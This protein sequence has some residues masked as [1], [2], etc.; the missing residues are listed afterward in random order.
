MSGFRITGSKLFLLSLLACLTAVALRAQTHGHPTTTAMPRITAKVDDANRVML[1]GNIHPLATA[2]HDLGAAP[3]SLEL[4]RAILVLKST[5]AQQAALTKLTDDQHNPKS[6]NYHVWLTPAEY[7][8]R[9]G[10]ASQDLAKIDGWLEGHGFTIEPQMAG[11]NLIIFSGTNAKLMQAFHT[12]L[13]TY[14]VKG[15]TYTA[16]SDNPQIPAAFSDLI[17]SFSPNNFPVQAQHTIPRLMKHTDAGWKDVAGVKPQT[18]LPQNGTT[19]YA[20]TPYDLATIYNILPLWNAGIDGTGETIAIVADSN[21]NPA[22]VDTFRS[23]FGLPAKKLNIINYGPDPGRNDDESEADLDVQWSGAV[24]KNATIDLVVANNSY[25]S[26]GI[27]GSAA[28]VVNNNLAPLLNV[29]FGACEQAFGTAENQ[30]INLLWQ[31]AASQ[32]I[33]VLVATGDSDAAGCD[34]GSSIASS[35]DA[36][37]GIASTPYDISVGGTDFSGNFPDP[38]RYWSAENNATTA[39]SVLSYIPE[40]AWNNSCANPVIL[41]AELANG[42]TSDATTQALCNDSSLAQQYLNTDGGGGAASNCAVAGPDATN[43]CGS[44]Y[45]KPAWQSGVLGIPADGVRDTPDVSL[46]AGNGVWG[47]FYL[48]CDSDASGGS[49]DTTSYVSAGGTSFA[50][51]IFAGMLALVQ[52]KEQAA[53]LGNVN[54]VLYKLGAAEYNNPSSTTCSSSSVTPGNSCIFYDITQGSNSAPCLIYTP[55]CG[56]GTA[57]ERIGTL[58]GY[59]ANPGY[60]VA[61]GLGTINAY[62][63]V[64]NW[65]SASSTFLP[66]T[67]RV[68]LTDPTSVVY[69]QNV[70]LSVVVSPIAPATG[71]PSGDVG[72]TSNDPAP[73]SISLNETTLSQGH[74]TV[75][76]TPLSAGSYQ[77]FANYAGDATFAPSA[78]SG[79]T[80]NVVKASAGIVLTSTSSVVQSS[81]NVT[82]SL[83][84]NSVLNGVAPTGTVIFTN[85]ATGAVLTNEGLAESSTF[86]GITTATWFATVP[87]SQLQSGANTITASYS[88]DSNYLG[89]LAAP[90][91]VSSAQ[92]AFVTTISQP[93]VTLTNGSGSLSVLITPSGSTPLTPNSIVLSC[94]T[95]VGLIC[96]FSPNVVSN[97]GALTST[98]SVRLAPSSLSLAASRADSNNAKLATISLAGGMAGLMLLMVPKRRKNYGLLSLCIFLLSGLML[99]VGCSSG[100]HNSSSSQS[101]LVATSTLLSVNSSTQLAGAA[102]VFTAK[103]KPESGTGLPTGTI[104]FSAGSAKLGTSPLIGESATFTTTSLPLGS[105]AVIATYSGDSTY[106]ISSSAVMLLNV[107]STVALKVAA[108]DAFSNQSSVNV[109]VIIQ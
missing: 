71:V 59:Y 97:S 104:M 84:A 6:P 88:G 87:Q 11:R 38:T 70:S 74:G 62:N 43:P 27:F 75:A 14:K 68:S 31:Q 72:F 89:A 79:V 25:A 46:M 5:S 7:G 78:S 106:E 100:I 12:E 67:T 60:D 16:L 109:A 1:P 64:E 49:C 21:I 30:F 83:E 94:P 105:Q 85:T 57:V 13:H 98:L 58:A 91:S 3:A 41:A 102:T 103:V 10:I 73:N 9:F 86:N 50:A 63:L 26:G 95:A 37:N 40:T 28:Y 20:V 107:S 52:Q 39:Q 69:G 81:Q 23:A 54:Y 42:G 101:S 76:T 47:S 92:E 65:N 80:V 22:D 90:L 32:G 77:L 53:G 48:A 17:L 93:S 66:T 99:T 36:P 19:Y 2:G 24:A 18:T 34:R 96:T 61:S 45:P 4:G 82:F 51:P 56:T 33:T 15:G 29:S 108:T 35:G 44:G 55:D 8:A